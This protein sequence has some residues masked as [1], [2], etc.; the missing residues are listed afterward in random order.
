[1]ADEA[2]LANIALIRH[3]IYEML[4]SDGFRIVKTG[5][6]FAC[7]CGNRLATMRHLQCHVQTHPISMQ[8]QMSHIFN[9][10]MKENAKV[11]LCDMADSVLQC[12]YLLEILREHDKVSQHLQRLDVLIS[13]YKQISEFDAWF[14]KKALIQM[15]IVN[16]IDPKHIKKHIQLHQEMTEKLRK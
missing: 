10:R 15:M 8:M 5:N 13:Y 16:E 14:S 2:L 4:D 11:I 3:E 6:I 1:M 9:E 12:A 7:L